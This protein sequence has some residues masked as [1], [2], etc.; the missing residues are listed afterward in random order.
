MSGV[1]VFFETPCTCDLD[2]ATFVLYLFSVVFLLDKL[3]SG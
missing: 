1:P 3:I 2:Y